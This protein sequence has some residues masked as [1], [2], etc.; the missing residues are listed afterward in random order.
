MPPC[1]SPAWAFLCLTLGVSGLSQDPPAKAPPAPQLNLEQQQKAREWEKLVEESRRI[2][3]EGGSLTDAIK[4]A[5]GAAAAARAAFGDADP[6]VLDAVG[7]LGGLYLDAYDL[8]A[9]LKSREEFVT[10]AAKLY[11]EKHWRT[12]DA[13]VA[14]RY[15]ERLQRGTKEDWEKV[16]RSFTLMRQAEERLDG[17]LFADA[18]RLAREALAA[19]REV[20][21]EDHSY[22][23]LA[24]NLLA[25]IHGQ[26]GDDDEAERHHR[27]AA[28][29][30]RKSMGDSH[31]TTYVLLNS[32][33]LLHLNRG[34]FDSAE[35]VLL[36]AHRLAAEY[37]GRESRAYAQ[38][39]A[40][41]GQ[42]YK[43]T[44]RYAKAEPLM[45]E[46]AERYR[47]TLGDGHPNYLNALDLL[48]GL[49]VASRDFA[50]A[51]RLYLQILEA[52]KT[53]GRE[54]TLDY[55]RY[56][57]N[58]GG[59]YAATGEY[60]K[61]V[62]HLR[63]ATDAIRKAL[64]ED[65]PFY[66]FALHNL[67]ATYTELE[68]FDT[69]EPL[70]RSAL[71]IR[72][73]KQGRDSP[74]Y[75][76]TLNALSYLYYAKGE[77]EKGKA[78]LHESLD[79]REKV[80]GA[81]HPDHVVALHNLAMYHR[82]A[83]ELDRAA[84]LSRA[85]L[86]YSRVNRERAAAAQSERQQLALAREHRK[87]LDHYL[88]IA[89]AANLPAADAYDQVL[90]WKGEV[91]V[92][93]RRAR[94]FRRSLGENPDSAVAGLLDKLDAVTRELARLAFAVPDP[95]GR[96]ERAK[97]LQELADRKEAIEADLAGR[98]AAF[99]D[100]PA[101]PLPDAAAL[102][103][104]VP[105]DAVL[106]DFLAYSQTTP[107]KSG[108]TWGSE[109]RLLAFVVR[110]GRPVVQFDL[111]PLAPVA[112]AVTAWRAAHSGARPPTADSGD[113]AADLRKLLWEPLTPHLAGVRSVLVSPDGPLND[114]PFPALPGAKPGT[115][116]VE[117][118][119]FAVVPVPQLLPDLAAPRA[120]R[121]RTEPSL[122]LVGGIDFG[123]PPDDASAG[124]Q[125][126][127]NLFKPL[128]G[129]ES[130]VNDLRARFEDAFDGTATVL[131]R[132]RATK[133]AFRREAPNFH[134]LH[135]AT[136]GFFAG[137]SALPATATEQPA[138]AG[139]A[140]AS[141]AAGWNPGLL[142]GVVFAGVNRG[143]PTHADA[144]LTATE[145]A[146]LDLRKAELVVL[147]ACDT[148]RGRVAGGEGVLG[149]QRAFQLAGAG[150]VV[151]SLWKVDDTVTHRLMR[152]F[153]RNLWEGRLPKAEALR[154]AQLTLLRE[155]ATRGVR[156]P[157]EE[158][159]GPTPPY[160][161]AAFVLSG[162]WR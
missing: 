53:T 18:A 79:V 5:E 116:L 145:A 122:L 110:P 58:L 37:A 6:R 66:A 30:W 161:W 148:G 159:A 38:S 125:G 8:A 96:A 117:E 70:L 91:L 158:S 146:E 132:D 115:F 100:G 155:G 9:A 108:V 28:E 106:I 74:G 40:N 54:G 34:R 7:W 49:H 46:A 103:A 3:R 81:G 135:L 25:A 134:F 64:G 24:H 17:R 123:T 42:L 151:A 44:G 72:A 129:T 59:L 119:V 124:P 57:L 149:L 10:I 33:G 152:E 130:E 23:A 90:G 162:D 111:G 118:Y 89:A 63:S 138:L 113:P 140:P 83:G 26:A 104:A 82:A 78:L 154:Q 50:R 88:S 141:E 121:P 67:G 32:L 160:F 71:E 137:E 69:A 105:A 4:A 48:A 156:P 15:V 62:P 144:I 101:R 120:D 43:Q 21:G 127:R 45:R 11:G 85:C 51:E 139:L 41:L 114:L 35:P 102:A 31:P 52:E 61:A 27:A 126:E 98:S 56:Q 22:T 142:S 99:R 16:N 147:S 107:P 86:A 2:A 136:H 150:A 19:R 68:Q 55:A 29:A 60:A 131:R 77:R 95:A 76:Y 93:Q 143:D 1:R 14:L 84:E 39:L 87:E 20:L 92:R 80:F 75:A 97:R 133:A 12:A 13:R 94:E 109:P 153:Y 36:E 47:Q 73:R 112:Q 128:P 157:G 65:H